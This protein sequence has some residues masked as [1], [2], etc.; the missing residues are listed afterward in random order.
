VVDV[1]RHPAVGLVDRI[2]QAAQALDA[3]IR[4]DP[5]LGGKLLPV[6]SDVE[7]LGDD[8]RGTSPGP[9]RVEGDVPL[10]HVAFPRA[11]A[12]LH[13]GHHHAVRQ[14]E[15]AQPQRLQQRVG[16]HRPSFADMTRSPRAR[17]A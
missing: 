16:L 13:G 10:R 6:G 4:I 8:E 14:S 5:Q 3:S 9:P 17:S 7:R 11:V 15:S 2:D 1:C 12:E